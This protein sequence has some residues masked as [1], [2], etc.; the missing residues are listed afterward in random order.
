MAVVQ[1]KLTTEKI[2]ESLKNFDIQKNWLVVCDRAYGTI[3]SMERVLKCG[4]QF[5]L[6]MRHKAF[7]VYDAAGRTISV[8]KSL[9]GMEVGGYLNLNVFYKLN[10][11]LKPVRLCVYRMSEEAAASAIRKVHRKQSKKQLKFSDDAVYMHNFVVVLTSLPPSVSTEEIIAAYRFRWQIEL[12]FK[13][14]KSILGMGNIPNKTPESIEAWLYG[15]ILYA[16]LIDS[17]WSAVDFSPNGDEPISQEYMA[18]NQNPCQTLDKLA[19][20]PFQGV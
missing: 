17:F 6:R 9:S 5:I 15:K 4:G 7:N 2:G 18:R 16:L 13:R 20:Q 8:A 14:L 19:H 3:T 10:G 12:Y 1:F 11:V